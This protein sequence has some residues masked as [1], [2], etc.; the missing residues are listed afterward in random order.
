LLYFVHGIR[1]FTSQPSQTRS[2]D[3]SQKSTRLLFRFRPR[4]CLPSRLHEAVLS[5]ARLSVPMAYEPDVRHPARSYL[6]IPPSPLPHHSIL[7]RTSHLSPASF[8]P[9]AGLTIWMQGNL[10][11]FS[12]HLISLRSAV[13][14]SET[15]VLQTSLRNLLLPASDFDKRWRYTIPLVVV[16]PPL[17]AGGVVVVENGKEG[18]G[19]KGALSEEGT[20]LVLGAYEGWKSKKVERKGKG[21]AGGGD[22]EMGG[23]EEKVGERGERWTTQEDG[24]SDWLRELELLEYVSCFVW[25]GRETDERGLSRTRIQVLLLLTLISIPISDCAI[26]PKRKKNPERHAS[27]LDPE[28]LLD[29]LTD[30]LQVWSAIK[31]LG[32]TGTLDAPTTGA[33]GTKDAPKDDDVTWWKEIVERS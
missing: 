19:N 10:D 26:P 1:S 2:L 22:V 23:T 25:D 5:P 11:T 14:D 12:H 33:D 32:A 3:A 31:S 16:P 27:T 13:S 15:T 30:R 20:G 9:R 4:Q 21:G 17:T 28:L 8:T 24:A 6:D 18:K 7:H 29:F